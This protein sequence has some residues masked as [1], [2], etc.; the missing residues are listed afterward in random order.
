MDKQFE[1]AQR[2]GTTTLDAIRHLNAYLTNEVT[3]ACQH[4]TQDMLS[5][6]T[7]LGVFMRYL[8]W[9]YTVETIDHPRHFQALHS[10]IRAELE[11][12]IDMIYLVN[13]HDGESLKKILTW[14]DGKKIDH[15]RGIVRFCEG[16]G[17]DPALEYGAEYAY[18]QR[19]GDRIDRAM[20]DVFGAKKPTG[21]WT[22]RDLG[23]DSRKADELS[24]NAWKLEEFYETQYRQICWNVHGSGLVMTRSFDLRTAAFLC[25]IALGQHLDFGLGMAQLMLTKL[26]T[27]SQAQVS[28]KVRQ[29]KLE[30]LTVQTA[31]GTLKAPV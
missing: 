22:G 9:S 14:E 5:E 20:M 8:A 27:F 4:V 10:A 15:I 17:L 31:D 21:R 19:N 2:I 7:A 25:A 30:V 13:D 26:G 29:L 24:N 1:L 18:L 3:P 11:L 23:T 16:R 6:Y 12:I 28:D